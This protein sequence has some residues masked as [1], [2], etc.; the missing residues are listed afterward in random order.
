MSYDQAHPTGAFCIS[1]P[2][3]C[4]VTVL[5]LESFS[6]FGFLPLRFL[7]SFYKKSLSCYLLQVTILNK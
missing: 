7:F 3:F 5:L 4:P 1:I 2:E 6:I